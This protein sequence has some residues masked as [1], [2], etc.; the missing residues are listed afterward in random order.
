VL[1]QPTV[2]SGGDSP[3]ASLSPAALNSNGLLIA[4]SLSC[5]V[6]VL[7][8]IVAVV[9]IYVLVNGGYGPFLRALVLGKRAGRSQGQGKGRDWGSGARAGEAAHKNGWDDGGWE[10]TGAYEFDGSAEYRVQ[11]PRTQGR[12]GGGR[13]SGP[14]GSGSS[15]SSGSSGGY[16]GKG[17]Y[18]GPRS[19]PQRRAPVR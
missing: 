1:A 3:L 16:G 14:R 2:G 12:N 19:G 13:N 8:L 15:G 6:A 9:A 10:Q 18:D 7:G 11:S 4:T 5:V 17:A